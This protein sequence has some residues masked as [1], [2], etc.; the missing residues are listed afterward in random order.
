[1]ERSILVERKMRAHLIVIGPVTC[2]LIAKVPFPQHHDMVEALAP[3]RSDQP[4]N[5]SVSPRRTWHSR[6]IDPIS[7]LN[8]TVLPRRAWRDRPVANAHSSQSARDRCTIG[9]VTIFGNLSGDPIGGRMSGDI[10]PD[11]LSPT[12]MQDDQSI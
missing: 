9:G 3:D 5:M 7:R 12:Q 6:R 4:F 1:V 8:M 2:Q 10:G 11:E